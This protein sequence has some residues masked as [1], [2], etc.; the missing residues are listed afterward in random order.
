MKQAIKL[1]RVRKLVRPEFVP[2]WRQYTQR[3]SLGSL[4]MI[5][6]TAQGA[7]LSSE[8][9]FF[10]LSASKN[11]K[12]LEQPALRATPHRRDLRQPSSAWRV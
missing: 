12:S 3:S 8:T 6:V 1:D 10:S 11:L 9:R 2:G 4:T 7:F 5:N